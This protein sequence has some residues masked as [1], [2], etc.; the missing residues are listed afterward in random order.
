MCLSYLP[1]SDKV[2]ALEEYL[3]FVRDEVDPRD[4]ASVGASARKLKELAN[5]RTFV[6]EIFNRQLT[7]AFD[8]LAFYSPQSAILGASQPFSVRLNVW[9]I[10]SSNPRQRKI[11]NGIYSYGDAH[12]HNFTFMTVGYYGPGYETIIYEYDRDQIV[13]YVGEHVDIRFL[14]R[15]FLPVGKVMLYR[16]FTDIHTQIPPTSF[17][18]SINLLI[19]DPHNSVTQQYYFDIEKGIICDFVESLSTK[20]VS[21]L[22]CLRFVGNENSKDLLHHLSKRHPCVRTRWAAFETLAAMDPTNAE[23]YWAGAEQDPDRLVK[24][25]ALTR[26][27]A[28][29]R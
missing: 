5:N 27:C 20:R 25:A 19:S 29:N 23:E 8:T 24:H 11:E 22:E 10:V 4:L 6:A 3:D 12:D 26:L 16:P 7:I 9:P 28:S 13:G 1:E 21:V 14:E 2:L 15:T 18:M 17:S